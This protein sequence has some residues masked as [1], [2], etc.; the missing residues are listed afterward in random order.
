MLGATLTS[1]CV[2]P[3]GEELLMESSDT[4]FRLYHERDCCECVYVEDVC[5]DLRDLVGSPL[6]VAEECSSQERE[7]R[8][9]RLSDPGTLSPD[10]LIAELDEPDQA[11][12]PLPTLLP[13]VDADSHTWTFYRFA[14]AKGHVTVRFLG[15]SN[16]YYSEG[17]TFEAKA[18]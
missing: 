4:R 16:G 1:A 17:V 10:D 2:S 12:V 11:P 13:P 7:E 18:I 9:T 8:L 14:T 5:G 6:L 15:T 3:D